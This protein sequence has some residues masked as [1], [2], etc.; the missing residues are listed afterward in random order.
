MF[1]L[2]GTSVTA[3]S[4]HPGAVRTDLMR[5]V[6]DGIHR[7]VP[8]IVSIGY[9]LYWMISKSSY[10]GAQTSIHCAVDDSVPDHNGKYFR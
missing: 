9:P 8:I 7:L 2:L 1:I 6:G 4:V 3:V 10:E 5:N